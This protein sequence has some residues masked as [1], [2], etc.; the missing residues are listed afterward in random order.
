MADPENVTEPH[1]PSESPAP[2]SEQVEAAKGGKGDDHVEQSGAQGALSSS[3]PSSPN[4]KRLK[5]AHLQ[6]PH[7]DA[8]G[9]K[10]CAS[11]RRRMR[12]DIRYAEQK[13]KRAERRKE[14]RRLRRERQKE[15][16]LTGA[17]SPVPPLR[18]RLHKMDD[19]DAW[20]HRVC[21]DLD[22]VDYMA[23]KDLAKV[24]KQVRRCYARNR[25]TQR[26]LQLHVTSLRP[27]LQAHLGTA[28]EL[29]GWDVHR[30]AEDY[31]AVFAREELV[32]LTSESEV[33]LE[34]LD[35][36][37]VY[38]I[39]GLVDHNVHKGL[40][41]RLAAERGIATARLPIGDYVHLASRKVLTINHVFEILLEYLATGSWSRAFF[42]VIPERKGLS[43][44]KGADDTGDTGNGEGSASGVGAT[45]EGQEHERSSSN[46][47]EDDEEGEEG[48]GE[49][50]G[51][52]GTGGTQEEP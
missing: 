19:P 40:T 47:S 46:T 32:Y 15:R 35:P 20:P 22:F 48:K 3:S 28:K 34:T 6:V 44:K 43:A 30:H 45:A 33:T 14:E 16:A 18:R 26:A 37:K 8:Q 31:G 41:A 51:E 2:A 4:S 1:Q 13:A 38:V 7:V 52:G 17:A 9:N 42:K 49:G 11:D 12:K 23:P 21:L 10:I 29:K 27:P 36:A 5:Y 25:R 50:E 39:G 24:G